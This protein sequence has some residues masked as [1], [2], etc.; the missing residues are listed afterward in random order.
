[1]LIPQF[2]FYSLNNCYYETSINNVS[3]SHTQFIESVCY[4]LGYMATGIA[5]S[6]NYNKII[7]A[8]AIPPI[9]LT[10]TTFQLNLSAIPLNGLEEIP[11][12][13]PKKDFKS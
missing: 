13:E 12:L 2:N 3:L 9:N 4:K 7:T 5:H 8:A 11:K 6:E 1:M 10:M